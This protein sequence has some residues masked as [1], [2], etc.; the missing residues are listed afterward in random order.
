[1][2]KISIALLLLTLTA[3]FSLGAMAEKADPPLDAPAYVPEGSI[4]LHQERDDGVLEYTYWHGEGKTVYEVKLHPDTRDVLK[5]ESDHLYDDGSMNVVLTEQDVLALIGETYP[6]ARNVQITL[7][8]D[9]GLKAYRAQFATALFTARVDFH[10]ETGVVLESELDYTR[11][12]TAA[13][14]AAPA[15]QVRQEAKPAAAQ[16]ASSADNGLISR[17]KASSI[18]LEKAGGGT[19]RYIKL[20]RDDGRQ[21]YEGEVVNGQ[22]E[23]EFEIDAR[24]GKVR[25]WDKDRMD[26]D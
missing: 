12:V 17:D 8:T 5:V 24:T 2:K 6:D 16:T 1:M 13:E 20:E 25:E 22:Y 3:F 10:P 15:A 21:V 19:V 9:D 18:A 26:N 23:Y 11:P 4:L 14:N 7:R